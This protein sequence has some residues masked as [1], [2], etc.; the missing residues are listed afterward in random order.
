MPNG[1][2]SLEEAAAKRSMLRKLATGSPSFIKMGRQPTALRPLLEMPP[3]PGD[4]PS[5]DRLRS[6][7]SGFERRNARHPVMSRAQ[8][9]V[10]SAFGSCRFRAV[11]GTYVECHNRTHAAQRTTRMGLAY[12]ITSSARASSVGGT[13]RPSAL[14]VFKLMTSSKVVG[15]CTGRLAGFSP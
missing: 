6:A 2:Y 15:C 13:S 4:F 9:Q 5:V 3:I 7:R 12:S 8:R 10:R 14:A 11:G 1:S